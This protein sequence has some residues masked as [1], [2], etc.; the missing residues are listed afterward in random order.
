MW[1]IAGVLLNISWLGSKP[2]AE[3]LGL[4]VDAE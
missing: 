3:L 4:T 1:K 2:A